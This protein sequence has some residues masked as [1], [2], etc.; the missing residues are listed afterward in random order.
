MIK[1]GDHWNNYL[2]IFKNPFCNWSINIFMRSVMK[3]LEIVLS[4]KLWILV[5][6]M[7]TATYLAM[8][9]TITGG[10]WVTVILA[11]AV[12]ITVARESFKISRLFNE[13][14]Q[15]PEIAEDDDTETT[16]ETKTNVSLETKTVEV[17][18]PIEETKNVEPNK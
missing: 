3:L 9:K 13:G 6:I 12:P 5:G 8:N 17:S 14:K 1:E 2:E 10:E 15:D 11:S 18:K 7:V 16:T 4:V